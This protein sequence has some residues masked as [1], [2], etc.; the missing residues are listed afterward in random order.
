MLPEKKKRGFEARCHLPFEKL[1]FPSG[2][3]FHLLNADGSSYLGGLTCGTAG[4][5]ATVAVL[6]WV[7]AKEG[8]L[9]NPERF[10]LATDAVSKLTLRFLERLDLVERGMTTLGVQ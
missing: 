9:E 6:R 1:Y 3:S 7:G 8:A 4:A 5:G 10:E 2:K